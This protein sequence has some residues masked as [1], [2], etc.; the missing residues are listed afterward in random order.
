MHVAVVLCAN[1]PPT[2]IISFVSLGLYIF[3]TAVSWVA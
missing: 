3:D 2:V 1:V